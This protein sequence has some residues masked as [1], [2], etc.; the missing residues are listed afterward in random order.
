MKKHLEIDGRE[1]DIQ[2]MCRFI[3]SADALYEE[4]YATYICPYCTSDTYRDDKPMS[5]IEHD[6]DCIYLIAKDLSTGIK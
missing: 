6:D 2:T 4:Y 1:K 5:H 3:M